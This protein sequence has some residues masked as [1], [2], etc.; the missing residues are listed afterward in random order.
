LDGERVVLYDPAFPLFNKEMPR[1]EFDRKIRENPLNDHLIIKDTQTAAEKSAEDVFSEYSAL[2]VSKV[3]FV[4][5][6]HERPA[7]PLTR[8]TPGSE[9]DAAWSASFTP[10]TR[11][12]ISRYTGP[13][14]KRRALHSE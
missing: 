8:R 4:E 12:S 5:A 9:C 6:S 14:R 11:W 7:N 3:L 13:L 10:L 1:A 2:L